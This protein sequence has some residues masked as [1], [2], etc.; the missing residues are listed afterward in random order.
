MC[1]RVKKSNWCPARTNWTTDPN[2]RN[3]RTKP[4]GIH[5]KIIFINNNAFIRSHVFV[6]VLCLLITAICCVCVVSFRFVSFALLTRSHW[7]VAGAVLPFANPNIYLTFSKLTLSEIVQLFTNHASLTLLMFS[8]MLMVMLML[9]MCVCVRLLLLVYDTMHAGMLPVFHVCV[10][11]WVCV[12]VCLYFAW[13][14]SWNKIL[15]NEIHCKTER[16]ALPLFPAHS[17]ATT[18][19]KNTHN[20]R[21]KLYFCELDCDCWRFCVNS[22]KK[23]LRLKFSFRMLPG[24]FMIGRPKNMQEIPRNRWAFQLFTAHNSITCS[25][26]ICTPP[27]SALSL[28]ICHWKFRSSERFL[29]CFGFGARLPFVLFGT[30]ETKNSFPPMFWKSKR[31]TTDSLWFVWYFFYQWKSDVVALGVLMKLI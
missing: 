4:N 30:H 9:A 29:W 1:E 13:R 17:F 7:P 25:L 3:G 12:C 22:S 16:M 18:A 28:T 15:L 27:F 26:W 11:D 6:L 10:S 14:F 8:L 19:T 5:T 31:H 20:N 23:I 2:N 21:R 24:R